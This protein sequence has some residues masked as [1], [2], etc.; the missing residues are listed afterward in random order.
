[1]TIFR[2]IFCRLRGIWLLAALA[3]LGL[4]GQCYSSIPP[5]PATPAGPVHRIALLGPTSGELDTFGRMMRNGI[6][7]AFDEWNQRGGVLDHRLEWTL[8]DTDC[9]FETARQA[10]QQAIDDGLQV[11]I[12]PLCSEA[13]IAAATVAEPAN[14]LMISPAATHPLVTVNRQAET[15]PTIF[16]VSYSYTWQGQ[17]TARFARDVVGVSQVALLSRPGNS[18]T[19]E[20][21]GAFAR[22]FVANGGE[23]VYRATYNSDNA[24]FTE[25]LR[26][27]EQVGAE[28]IY[29]PASASVA[30]RVADRLNEL[31]LSKSSPAAETGL[32]LLGSDAWESDEL[33]LSLMSGSYFPVHFQLEDKNQSWVESYKATYAG[34][35][36]SLS[37]LGYDAAN[38]VVEAIEQAGTF[39]TTVVAKA[40][41]QGTFKGV[42]GQTS[43]DAGHNPIKPIPFLYVLNGKTLHLTSIEPSSK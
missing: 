24:D 22:E 33:D 41:E 20:L 39:E 43:F 6:V 40:L 7:L 28:L 10:A 17:I 27:I 5:L 19:T 12:G 29:L 42:T 26:A 1:M 23:I 8:Y 35:P 9:T 15:R 34:E 16:R 4:A 21:A 11:I 25:D 37:A 2:Q 32:L 31:A 30:N 18:Y 13:A 3:L 38:M 36:S 14:V